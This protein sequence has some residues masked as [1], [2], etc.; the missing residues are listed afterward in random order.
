M[1]IFQKGISG[2]GN[3]KGY[4]LYVGRRRVPSSYLKST[5]DRSFFGV[6][7]DVSVRV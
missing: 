6:V 2:N 5:I 4:D 3:K 7:K 1:E